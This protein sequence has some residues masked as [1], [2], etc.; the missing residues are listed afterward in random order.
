MKLEGAA[1]RE[2]VAIVPSYIKLKGNCTTIYTR[3]GSSYYVDK[4]MDTVL[5]WLAD[6]YFTDLK[7]TRKYCYE[8]L[9]LKVLVPI[10]FNNGS[11]F[12]PI[13]VRTPIFENDGSTGYVDLDY[14]QETEELEDEDGNNV[15]DVHLKNEVTIRCLNRKRTVD[16]RMRD[17]YIIQRFCSDRLAPQ[18]D[19]KDFYKEYDKPATKGDIALL[20]KEIMKLRKLLKE[21]EIHMLVDK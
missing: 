9:A 20:V 8:I 4:T 7:A 11:V 18:L 5:K 15:T 3:R 14:I 17:G 12:I 1:L 2:I 6:Y 16:K 21:A 10:P 13:R 19:D